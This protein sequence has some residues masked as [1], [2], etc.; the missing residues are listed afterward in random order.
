VPRL[1][2]FGPQAAQ[3]IEVFSDFA[4]NKQPDPNAPV[5]GC[6][7]GALTIDGRAVPLR[8]DA[9]VGDVLSGRPVPVMSCEDRELGAGWHDVG[10]DGQVLI[11]SFRLESPGRT[12]VPGPARR[13]PAIVERI[14]PTHVRLSYRSSGPTF[15]THVQSF[16][17][18]WTAS[19]N[20]RPA[21]AGAPADTL[22]GWTVGDAGPVVVDLRFAPARA[23]TIALAV[24]IVAVIACLGLAVLGGG[25]RD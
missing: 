3:I 19:I 17:A 21:R 13:V 15:V 18:G 12:P 4:G 1:G 20:G 16:D 23:F 5:E 2:P 11:D 8:T 10:G 9:T 24:T 7:A 25:R 6:R 22:S 14:S